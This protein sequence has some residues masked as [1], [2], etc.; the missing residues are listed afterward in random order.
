MHIYLLYSESVPL[1]REAAPQSHALS[2]MFSE[3]PPNNQKS[4]Q[5][6]GAPPTSQLTFCME[7]KDP[8]APLR[9][10]LFAWMRGYICCLPPIVLSFWPEPCGV[11]PV[12]ESVWD[13]FKM[14]LSVQIW[15][16]VNNCVLSQQSINHT[17]IRGKESQRNEN[18]KTALRF[19]NSGFPSLS[20]SLTPL[21]SELTLTHTHG[22]HYTLKSCTGWGVQI[23]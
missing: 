13:L 8:S 3:S 4:F 10:T 14:T 1:T 19:L 7:L 9:C 21:P 17:K 22:G 6:S 20:L 2:E 11:R 23:M 18:N 15:V 5:G 16:E 12:S